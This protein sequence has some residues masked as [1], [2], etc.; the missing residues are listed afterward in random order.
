MREHRGPCTLHIV[1]SVYP[2]HAMGSGQQVES[3]ALLKE[4]GVCS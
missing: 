4:V 2:Q 1:R 3:L